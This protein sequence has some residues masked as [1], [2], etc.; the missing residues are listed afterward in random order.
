LGSISTSISAA[1]RRKSGSFTSR[2][3]AVRAP[4]CAQPGHRGRDQRPPSRRA[5]LWNSA[6]FL[7]VGSKSLPS[8]AR[9]RGPYDSRARTG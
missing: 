1:C 4:R 2:S 9:R 7:P 3:K 8:A 5:A 6:T